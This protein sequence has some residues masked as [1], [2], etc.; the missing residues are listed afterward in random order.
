M[1]LGAGGAGSLAS[2]TDSLSGKGAAQGALLVLRRPLQQVMC[3]CCWDGYVTALAANA[4]RHTR[5]IEYFSMLEGVAW[6]VCRCCYGCFAAAQLWPSGMRK[7]HMK[8][9]QHA[10]AFLQELYQ[11]LSVHGHELLKQADP[12]FVCCNTM[13]LQPDMLHS[14]HPLVCPQP[15]RSV[16]SSGTVMRLVS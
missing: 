6:G 2:A 9:L 5:C 10:Y 12:G 15:G 7:G 16:A 3:G 1:P 14:P 8:S 4:W 13:L 11:Y